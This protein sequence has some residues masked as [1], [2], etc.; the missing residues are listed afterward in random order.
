[1][2]SI[3]DP[4][5]KT[6]LTDIET[7]LGNV[8]MPGQMSVAPTNKQM[9]DAAILRGSLELLK[10]KQPNENFAS[11]A[12]RALEAAGQPAKTLAEAQLAT[13]KARGT[14]TQL[15]LSKPELTGISATIEG[16]SISNKEIGDKLQKY[17]D[18]LGDIYGTNKTT[19]LSIATEVGQLQNI[20][21]DAQITDL[22]PLALDNL[23]GNKSSA[24]SSNSSNDNPDEKITAD[25]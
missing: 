10:P 8:V 11:Q 2:A 5:P 9:I 20:Y 14:S 4:D 25:D 24:P 6:G 18:N 3:F 19:L 23:L 13:A 7:L 12:S 22:I 21:K 15:G 17:K 1:M 16:L